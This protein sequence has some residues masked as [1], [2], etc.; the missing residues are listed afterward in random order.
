MLAQIGEYLSCQP[1][2]LPH[3]IRM[4]GQCPTDAVL[5]AHPQRHTAAGTAVA[6]GIELLA[7]LNDGVN[8]PL[9]VALL[10][11]VSGFLFRYLAVVVGLGFHEGLALGSNQNLGVYRVIAVFKDGAAGAGTYRQPF[12]AVNDFLR[13]RRREQVSPLHVFAEDIGDP[14][15][16]PADERDA[17]APRAEH[18][19]AKDIFSVSAVKFQSMVHLIKLYPIWVGMA[20]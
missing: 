10:E 14:P 1:S 13:F 7:A 8:Q 19:E 5:L 18:I 9:L 11:D 4:P 3:N 12:G 20:D 2:H 15:H 17:C 16:Q 6:D